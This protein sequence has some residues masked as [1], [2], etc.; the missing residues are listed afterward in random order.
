[1]SER[2]KRINF[3]KINLEF[4]CVKCGECCKGG[5]IISILKED[6]I[7]WQKTEKIEYLQNI[8]IDPNC[9]SL[10]DL[11]KFNYKR[12][13][14]IEIIKKNHNEKKSDLNVEKIIEF[15]KKSHL[16][17]G[18]DSNSYP[19]YTILPNLKH[20]P[21]LIPRDFNIVLKG[22][23]LGLTYKIIL[24]SKGD[25]PFL[26]LNLCSINDFK[27]KVCRKF[28]YDNNGTLRE[29]DHFTSICRGL[30]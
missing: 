28:P 15:I 30:K 9:I 4:E 1:M 10:E 29:D 14:S 6:I 12:N 26:K 2:I 16:Y 18:K 19:I 20:S 22:F 3:N 13:K 8:T 25:C 7:K 27:P 11:S 21:I 24:N 17:Q 5:Y 23:E